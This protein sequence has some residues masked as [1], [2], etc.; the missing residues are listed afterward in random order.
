MTKLN[1]MRIVHIAPFQAV[2]SGER[3][4]DDI[5]G[6]NGFDSWCAAHRELLVEH[7]YEPCDFLWH[8]GEPATYG[9]GLNVLIKA[10]KPGTKPEDTAPYELVEFPGGDFLVAT[11]DERDLDDIE[12]TVVGMYEWINGSEVFEYG[13]FPQSGMCNMP[14]PDSEIDKALVIA[15]QQI[16]LP[17]KFRAEK[18]AHK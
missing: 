3:T 2:S 1:N 11:A 9:R 17:L 7:M 13:D 16:F 18:Q 5:F 14:A 15:Q 4:L 8:V 12:Q 6:E 10:V